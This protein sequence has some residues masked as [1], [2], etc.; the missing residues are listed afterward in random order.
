MPNPP[1]TSAPPSLLRRLAAIL[2][3]TLLLIAL[4]LA[5]NAL[6]F[7]LTG[8]K[9]AAPERPDWLLSVQRLALLGVPVWFF[10]WFW[11]HGGQTLGMRAWRLRLEEVNGGPVRLNQAA[12]RCLAALISFAALGLGYLWVLADPEKRSWHDRFSGT[13][14]V[15][16][17]KGR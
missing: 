10:V 16:V 17:P 3:D 1:A 6:L 9:L 7:A 11:M 14:L 12:M 13:R 4:W 8:G 5:V 2:Y 15:L